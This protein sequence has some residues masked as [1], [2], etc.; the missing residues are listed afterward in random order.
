MSRKRKMS[1]SKKPSLPRR[2][3]IQNLTFMGTEL[4]CP[5]LVQDM[6]SMN[7][8]GEEPP[9]NADVKRFISFAT[10]PACCLHSKGTGQDAQSADESAGYAML[11]FF[12]LYISNGF[13]SK[14][15]NCA[16]DEEV[17]E[18]IPQVQPLFEQF[19]AAIAADFLSISRCT[20]FELTPAARARGKELKKRV[21]TNLKNAGVGYTTVTPKKT[22]KNDDDDVEEDV[23]NETVDPSDAPGSS[24]SDDIVIVREV[25]S[26]AS[27]KLRKMREMDGAKKKLIEE[28]TMRLGENRRSPSLDSDTYFGECQQLLH[29]PTEVYCARP[30]SNQFVQQY[31]EANSTEASEDEDKEAVPM[32][33]ARVDI[34]EDDDDVIVLNMTT[35]SGVSDKKGSEDE[36]GDIVDEW[37]ANDEEEKTDELEELEDD[38]IQ[39]IEAGDQGNGVEEVSST[40]ISVETPNSSSDENKIYNGHQTHQIFREVRQLPVNYQARTI[41]VVLNE[42]IAGSVEK[43]VNSITKKSFN[44]VKQLSKLAWDHYLGNAQP[45]FV[46]LKK[47]EA[48]QKLFSEIKKLFPDTEIKLQTTGSTV[49]GCGSFNSDMDLCLCFP[50]NGYK[51]QVCDDFHCDRNYSTKI[52]RKIDKAFRRSHWSHPLK[53]IIKTMQL[54]PAKVPIVKMILN[55]E[56]DGIEVDINVNNIA[57]IYNSHLIHYYSLTDARLPALALLVKH[58][59]MVT[60]INNAQDGFLNSYTTIL[61]VVHYLQCGVTPAVIPN[62]QYLFPHKFDRK[63]PLNELLLFGDIAD[64]LPTSPPNTW[65]LGELL[66]GFFQYYNEFDFTNFGFSIRSGQVIPR[67]NLPRDL[68]NSPIVVEEPFDAINT[69]RTVR[70]VSH[71]KSIKSAFRCA[72]QIISSNK[73]FTMRDLGVNVTE[74]D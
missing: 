55:G 16:S 39:I 49:N 17:K 40:V 21:L 26:E 14:L 7:K 20:Q 6:D 9:E 56:F 19:K 70:D 51:G 15:L 63:L 65:S 22:L 4:G 1:Q 67:E 23:P 62:L 72:V 33:R 71:M 50:T 29:G 31:E 52:L 12:K 30:E 57:G 35:S 42:R 64:K 45:D 44:S 36:I 69:A 58:W 43:F 68:I 11:D 5:L 38:D 74:F 53:K 34:E 37:D 24:S 8:R 66:I 3:I 25:A 18:L 27:P 41:G 10:I 47:M 13:R 61:L 59:A 60:G 48:R 32:K 28:A 46:F 2:P 54:V 73:N